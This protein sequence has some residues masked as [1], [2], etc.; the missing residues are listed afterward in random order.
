MFGDNLVNTFDQYRKN[1]YYAISEIKLFGSCLCNGH[2]SKCKMI[3]SIQY[4]L[5]N[6]DKMV[7]GKCECKHNTQ[8]DNCEYCMD[9]Y[10]DRCQI[11]F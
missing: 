9:L 5:R 2:A 8:G 10:N 6:I 7:H 11:F 1:Y 4:D 3:D